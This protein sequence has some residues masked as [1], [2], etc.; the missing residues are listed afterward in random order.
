MDCERGKQIT[1]N[2]DESSMKYEEI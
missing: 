1:S 2:R